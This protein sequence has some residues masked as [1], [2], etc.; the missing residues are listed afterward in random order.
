MQ[1]KR[2]VI[3]ILLSLCLC[4][5]A[6]PQTVTH[7]QRIPDLSEPQTTRHPLQ[8]SDQGGELFR[9]RYEAVPTTNMMHRIRHGFSELFAEPVPEEDYIDISRATQQLEILDNEADDALEL[10]YDQ[11]EL[12]RDLSIFD[13]DR[14]VEVT[15]TAGEE[16]PEETNLLPAT[17]SF[18]IA[19]E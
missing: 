1:R 6:L 5:Q 16:L 15:A 17:V 18:P 13:P 9:L 11:L 7:W 12:I 8:R 19:G 10:G 4:N 2:T 3:T 14:T